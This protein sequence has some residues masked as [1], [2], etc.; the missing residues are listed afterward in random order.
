VSPSN[1][2]NSYGDIYE[3]NLEWAKDSSMN[4]LDK[5]GVPP[6]W[7]QYIKPFLHEEPP[8]KEFGNVPDTIRRA[9]AKL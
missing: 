9:S 2:G 3:Q 7:E 1:I 8:V 4:H 5:G 6:Q